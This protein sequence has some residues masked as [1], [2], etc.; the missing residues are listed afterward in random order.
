M[1]PRRLDKAV[2][3]GMSPP[4]AKPESPERSWTFPSY[5]LRR[6]E[7]ALAADPRAAGLEV[8]AFE[9][10]QAEPE[11]L[12]ARLIAE[13]P[14]LVGFSAFIWSFETFLATAERVRRELPDCRIVFGGP[15]AEPVQCALPRY[16][17]RAPAAIDVLVRGEGEE[18]IGELVAHW[19]ASDAR[20][21]SVAGLA[22]PG[23]GGF[24]ATRPRPLNERLDLLASPYQMGL[25]APRR[26]GY[27]ETFR[28]CPMSCT[29]CEWGAMG[30][31][32]FFSQAYLERELAAL[33]AAEPT[34]TYLVDAALNLNKRAFRNLA[35]AEKAVGCF[36]Q[37]SLIALFYPSLVDAEHLDFLSRVQTLYLTVGLQSLDQDVLDAID[38]RLDRER[39]LRVIRDMS[40]LRNVAELAVELIVGLPT[41][42]P[43]SFRRTL[44]EAM[45][46]G[47]AIRVYH[48]L[49]LPNGLMTRAPAAQA[50]RFDERTLK[51]TSAA[52]WSEAALRAELDRLSRLTGEIPGAYAAD[53]WW[54][55]PAAARPR[56]GARPA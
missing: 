47:G 23:E 46:L 6:I 26:V 13:R 35:A 52:G 48:C 29:F 22:L 4:L 5:G 44:D 21:E 37:R 50:I 41:D 49:V 8:A 30:A 31:G 2:L 53:Y 25:M 18:A 7:A 45:T 32:S 51:L 56:V 17:G 34:S 9:L 3:V 19:R 42:S 16:A 1:S 40:A 24:R 39:L 54:Y 43:E 27:L 38:R 10:P 33:A 36:R 55:F 12:A 20:P 11:E 14:D 28:G 15:G